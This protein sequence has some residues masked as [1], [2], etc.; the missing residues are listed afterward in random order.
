MRPVC[1]A[2]TLGG[3]HLRFIIDINAILMYTIRVIKG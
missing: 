2:K 3:C 1:Q